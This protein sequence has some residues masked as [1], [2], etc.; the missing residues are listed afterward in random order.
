VGTDTYRF[1]GQR[2]CV[3]KQVRTDKLDEAV[4]NDVCELLRNPDLLREEYERRLT[5]SGEPSS[6][7]Q[8]LTRQVE[9]SRRTVNRL[10]DAFSDGVISREEFDPR[11]ARARTQLTQREEALAMTHAEAAEREALQDSLRCLESFASQIEGGLSVADWNTRREIIRT[12]IDH[13]EVEPDQIRITYRINFPL[14]LNRKE[15]RESL[16]F[17]WRR[18]FASYR[19]S[20]VSSI[21][22]FISS[23]ES[24]RHS[25]SEHCRNICLASV[26]ARAASSGLDGGS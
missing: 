13:V 5:S 2:V 14:F 6:H 21:N 19:E 4:W 23:L 22:S 18:A 16:H 12:A 3:N 25:D 11:I 24:G 8:S 9:Q 17:R 7:R 26:P 20:W 15:N 10:I 1:G